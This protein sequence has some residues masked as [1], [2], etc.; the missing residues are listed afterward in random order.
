MK[1]SEM[2]FRKGDVVDFRGENFS[3]R[4]I[5]VNKK[6]YGRWYILVPGDFT[7]Y[8]AFEEHLSPVDDLNIFDILQE[9]GVIE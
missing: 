3:G 5:L 4:G 8:E 2:K 1:L 6:A 9:K 7:D